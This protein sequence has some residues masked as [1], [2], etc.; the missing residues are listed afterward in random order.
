MSDDRWFPHTTVA[1]ICE[2][3]DKFLMVQ[4]RIDDKI[5]INQPSGHLEPDES[6]VDA[7]KREVLE[8]TGYLFQPTELQAIYR[9]HLEGNPQNTYIRY[10]F[11]GQIGEKITE[12]LDEGIIAAN[13]IHKD[14]LEKDVHQHRT[15]MVLQC[16]KDYYQLPGINLSVFSI[17]FP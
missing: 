8:E 9:Y 6:L 2:Q 11:R 7:V 12:D 4:E 14:L 1:A 15:E 17:N 5:V 3:N 13:W 16:V 10:A